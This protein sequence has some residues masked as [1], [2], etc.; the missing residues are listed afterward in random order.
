MKNKIRILLFVLTLLFFATAVTVKNAVTDVDILNLET[1][2]FTTQLHNKEKL[3]YKIFSDSILHKT[4]V[5]SERYP[6]QVREIANKYDSEQIYLYIYKNSKP[7]F[8]SSNIYVPDTDLGLKDGI[9]YILADNFSF[10]VKKKKLTAEL[11]IVALIPID[12]QYNTSYKAKNSQNYFAATS[13][14]QLQV[15]KFGDNE[16][17]R[18]IYSTK[19]NYLFSVKL[20]SNKY[21]N[22]YLTI[23]LFCWVLGTICGVILISNI[24][25]NIARSGKPL[26]SILLLGFTF[27]VIRIIDLETNWLSQISDYK[28]FSPRTYAY[29]YLAPNLWSFLV[30]SIVLLWIVCFCIYIK[31]Y[32]VVPNFI[33]KY[34]VRNW[35]YLFLLLGIYYLYNQLFSQLATLITHSSFSTEDLI[36]LLFTY[37]FTFYHILIYAIIIFSIILMTDILVYIGKILTPKTTTNL[38][39]Q[40]ISLVITL[41]ISGFYQNFSLINILIGIL[42]MMQSFD[43]SMLKYNN[44][45]TQIIAILTLAC[46]TTIKFA[47]A[48]NENNREHMKLMLLNLEAD[49][50]VEAISLFAQIESEIE[51]DQQL[52]KLIRIT[53]ENPNSQLIDDYIQK[54]YLV[55]YL[56][57]YSFSGYYYLNEKALDSYNFNPLIDY[58]EKV[59]SNA[60][61]VNFTKSFYKSKTEIGHYDYFTL[62]NTEDNEGNNF[63]IIL[64]LKKNIKDVTT[65]IPFVTNNSNENFDNVKT[66]DYN[67][68]IYKNGILISQNGTYTYADKDQY[69]D[70]NIH[71][72]YVIDDNTNYQHIIF[73]PNKETTLIVSKLIQSYWQFITVVSITFLF[74]YI[75]INVVRFLV[76]IVPIYIRQDVTIINLYL[77]L[78]Y[79]L[80]Q[81]RYS[82]R[83]QTLVISSVLIAIII[84]GIISFYSIRLQTIQNSKDQKIRFISQVVQNLEDIAA[85]DSSNLHLS[86]LYKT[87]SSLT[88]I[89]VTDYNLYDKNGKLFFTTQ[90]NIY[91]HNLISSYINPHAYIEMNVLKKNETL[92]I[93]QIIDFDY[94]SA[95][96]T[97]KDAN[98]RTIAYLGIPYF[99]YHNDQT[100]STN[101]L[102]KTLLNIFTII[103]IIFAF[104]SLY[105]SNK[106]T[107]P[108]Q[109]IR[110]KLSQTNISDKPNESLYWEKDDEIGLLVKEYNYMLV[111]LEEH[112]KQLRHAERESVW[113]EMAQ[114]VAHEIKN[115]LTPMKL[116]IQQLNRSFKDNDDRFPERFEKISNSFIEQIDALAR[117]ASE[118]SAFAKLP[119]SHFV[120]LNLIEKINK[121][122]HVYDN[123]PNV[124]IELINETQF[125]NEI[126]IFGDRDQI[127]RSFNN[128]IKNAIEATLG[129]RK[130]RIKITIK[131]H[132][133][134]TIKVEISDNGFG[135]PDEVIPKI[136]KPNFTTKSSGTGLGLAFVKQTIS[137]IGG[138]IDYETK[139]NHGTNFIIILPMHIKQE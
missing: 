69:L 51:N 59:I 96:A 132:E 41:I 34:N 95:Y 35:V 89:V 33:L 20:K 137:G 71:E 107:E 37:D 18:N 124:S 74:L 115:P 102:L 67:F 110:K 62:I 88:E 15:A 65:H 9:S 24:C 8:W 79:S 44:L 53:S 4:F 114:Q 84:S 5:N 48:I 80:A 64:N 43:K 126:E 113:R 135:I 52:K 12:R 93:E 28:L 32:F 57:N 119:E 131:P 13:N 2:K 54:T 103:L 125:E 47:D 122:I 55:G 77:R 104:L 139:L 14:T 61:K 68:A 133:E 31:K 117:I 49:D 92:M 72:F 121:S 134:K 81:I 60:S 128:L 26:F 25:V 3:V 98:Y 23:Q 10:I 86:S 22:I 111:K 78:R 120:V 11:N 106:I 91:N 21:N 66:K 19:N 76:Q 85:K 27:S 105:I 56:T 94:E 99:N 127:I 50:D 40:L 116:G 17:I 58:R 16:E 82:S 118:F 38:N 130:P 29:N 136:F 45:Y 30:N 109:M 83:I 97:I 75:I 100:E 63:S 42:I 112:S 70:K 7:I 138:S 1:K 87:M 39:I 36:T 123:I 46:I 73:R 6:L 90:P 108:L 129:R 101:I